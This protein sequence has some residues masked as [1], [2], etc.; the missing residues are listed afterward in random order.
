MELVY[1]RA[2][3]LSANAKASAKLLAKVAQYHAAPDS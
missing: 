2:Y 3:P 1:S